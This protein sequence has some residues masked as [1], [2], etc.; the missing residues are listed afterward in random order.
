MQGCEHPWNPASFSF[1]FSFWEGCSGLNT[2]SREKEETEAETRRG[3]V[4]EHEK[5]VACG[6]NRRMGTIWT[7]AR[8]RLY[9]CFSAWRVAGIQI[10]VR[11]MTLSPHGLCG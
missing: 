4:S 3:R 8:L 9:M 5:T 11:A 6:G 7:W 1:S 2:K 10:L